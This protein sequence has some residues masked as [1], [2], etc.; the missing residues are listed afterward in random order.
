M[1][2]F[3]R[4]N[5]YTI[6]WLFVAFD[7]PTVTKKEKKISALFRKKLM[8]DGFNMFQYSLYLRHCP[9]IEN[10]QVHKNRIKK[11]LPEQGNIMMWTLTDKQFGDMETFY[12]KKT[13]EKPNLV[14]QLELF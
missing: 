11:I 5:K 1:N 14:Q 13:T 3:D 10:A 4:F 2:H 6:M 8:Q 12:G 9:S 7:L